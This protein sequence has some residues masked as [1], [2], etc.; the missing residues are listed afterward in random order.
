MQQTFLK[1]CFVSNQNPIFGETHL[2]SPRISNIGQ[3]AS[4]NTN[5]FSTPSLMYFKTTLSQGLAQGQGL[6]WEIVSGI[7]TYFEFHYFC[8]LV[9]TLHGR[10]WSKYSNYSRPGGGAR[11]WAGGDS[12]SETVSPRQCLQDSVSETPPYCS[13]GRDKNAPIMR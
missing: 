11:A 12:V 1:F 5:I 3:K 10:K 7:G 13:T 6:R 9:K 8:S 2:A 4:V